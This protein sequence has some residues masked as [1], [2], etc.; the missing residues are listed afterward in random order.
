MTQEE[1]NTTIEERIEFLS[2][3]IKMLNRITHI[4]G[5]SEIEKLLDDMHKEDI[6]FRKKNILYDDKIRNYIAEKS[7]NLHEL[8]SLSDRKR[9]KTKSSEIKEIIKEIISHLNKLM[10]VLRLKIHIEEFF[11]ETPHD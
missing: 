8:E 10:N 1:L 9:T 4:N 5:I 7:N 11:F 2:K 6:V 3:Y